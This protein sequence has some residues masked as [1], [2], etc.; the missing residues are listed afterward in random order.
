MNFESFLATF[1]KFLCLWNYLRLMHRMFIWIFTL[2][3]NGCIFH[4]WKSLRYFLWLI[5]ALIIPYKEW[6]IYCLEDELCDYSFIYSFIF[7]IY[8]SIYF[9]YSSFYSSIFIFLLIYIH[10]S[11]HLFS[12]FHLYF[13]SLFI[14]SSIFFIYSTIFFIYFHLYFSSIHLYSFIY[15]VCRPWI[16]APS[17]TWALFSLTWWW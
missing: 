12:S 17:R 6:V 9:I 13:S 16:T 3:V 7:F 4:D 14:Y 5:M 11:I 15:F 2:L 10:L 8:S 1:W